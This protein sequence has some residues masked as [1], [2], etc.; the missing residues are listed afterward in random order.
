MNFRISS[1]FASRRIRKI[2]QKFIHD[3]DTLKQ[4]SLCAEINSVKNIFFF[5]LLTTA[6][7]FPPPAS[8]QAQYEDVLYL[9]NGSVI[10]GMITE[11]VLN[12]SIKI[13]TKDRNVFVFSM[14]E[15]LKIT[16]EEIV[17]TK[18]KREPLT[19]DNIKKRG[20]IN[21][22]EITFGRDVLDNG[23]SEALEDYPDPE[24]QPSAGIQTVNGFLFNPHFSAG[25]GI[26]FHG[27][28][29]LAFVPFF[30]DV[31]VNLIKGP[32]APFFSAGAGYSFTAKE[33]YGL[34]Y[35]RKY[36][37]GIYFNPAMGIKFNTRKN[38]A[39]TFSLGYRQQEARIFT[40]EYGNYPYYNYNPTGAWKNYTLGYLNLKIGFVF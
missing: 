18:K 36:F 8:A 35:D 24:I 15:I 1:G 11:Q 17:V 22:T 26:G 6:I 16:K 21:I 34:N 40:T 29:E 37:G 13:Q 38:M 19:K 25:I 39:L 9:K 32:V 28:S 31:R 23:S 4:I 30:A 14:A 27:Y 2:F 3:R 10:R 33:V 20:F 5:F 12:E 7:F